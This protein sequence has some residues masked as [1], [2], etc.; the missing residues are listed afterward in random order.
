MGRALSFVEYST[1]CSSY[2]R[3]VCDYTLQN[4]VILAS[5]VF[6]GV[7]NC[8]TCRPG[9]RGVEGNDRYVRGV[10]V[11]LCIRNNHHNDLNSNPGTGADMRQ[12]FNKLHW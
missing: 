10:Y 4:T 5:I 1:V 2:N 12:F 6:I 7:S 8:V 11:S 3:I 9:L